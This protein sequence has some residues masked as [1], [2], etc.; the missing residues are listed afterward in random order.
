MVY[1][2]K[3]TFLFTEEELL[4]WW[5]LE[6]GVHTS[7][8]SHSYLILESFLSF[9]IFFDVFAGTATS[10]S[11]CLEFR[12]RSGTPVYLHPKNDRN[13]RTMVTLSASGPSLEGFRRKPTTWQCSTVD[14]A[15]RIDRP[16]RAFEPAGRPGGSWYA[17]STCQRCWQ[18]NLPLHNLH[19]EN[20]W[21]GKSMEI[22]HFSRIFG[23][24]FSWCSW[25]SWHGAPQ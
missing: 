10:K 14:E 21:N 18:K 2:T 3:P 13:D 24:L 25:S 15:R 1:F 9:L 4:K 23:H 11:P 16:K 19:I 12:I 5:I 22:S 8:H 6:V 17:G 20:H 7:C